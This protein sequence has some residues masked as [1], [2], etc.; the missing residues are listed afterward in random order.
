M[1]DLDKL[2]TLLESMDVPDMRRDVGND[3][4]AQRSNVRWLQRNLAIRNSNNTSLRET[5]GLLR[6]IGKV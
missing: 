6:S 5:F 1:N 4:P 2:K 3:T